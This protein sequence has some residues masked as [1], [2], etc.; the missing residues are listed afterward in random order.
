M[1]IEANNRGAQTVSDFGASLRALTESGQL[2]KVFQDREGV[3]VVMV[4]RVV[5]YDRRVKVN[6]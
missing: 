2:V 3:V 4:D 6:R 1:K 5:V